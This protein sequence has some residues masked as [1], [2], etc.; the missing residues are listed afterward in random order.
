MTYAPLN[1]Q[2]MREAICETGKRLY[3]LFLVAG[4]DGNISV[5]LNDNEVLITPSGVSKGHM[6]PESLIKLTMDDT[7]I[8]QPEGLKA[9]S[10]RR[11]HL[12]IY[13]HRPDVRAVVHAHP[14]TATGFSVA[15]IGIDRPFMA[16]TVVRTGSIPVVPYAIPGGNELPDSIVP[17]L[18]DSASLLLGNH[19]VVSYAKTLQEALFGMEAVE[20]D[21]RIYLTARQLGN[22]N[23]LT[24]EQIAALRA[25]YL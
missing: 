25:R 3:D 8:S 20:V 19:G 4:N 12:A 23:Y 10:E 11:M 16:E 13:R 5:R 17:F 15:G 9:S 21:A 6:T 14:P 7:V 18:Q 2:E 22:V 24:E 1:E